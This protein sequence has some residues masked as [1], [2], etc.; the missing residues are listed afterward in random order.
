MAFKKTTAGLLL[1]AF[2]AMAGMPAAAQSTATTPTSAPASTSS[3]VQ[4]SAI[5]YANDLHLAYIRSSSSRINDD[6]KAGLTNLSAQLIERT[7]VEPHGVVG[8]NIERDDLSF[9]PFIYWPV[10]KNE[11]PLSEQAQKKVQSYINTGGVILFDVRDQT[12]KLNKSKALR[13][14][15]G[16]IDIKPLAPMGQSHTLT[17]TFYLVTGLPG[18]N[19]YGNI[20][21]ETADANSQENVSSVIIGNKNWAGAWAGRTV[22]PDTDQEEMAIRAGINI[23]MFALSGNYK[24]DQIQIPSILERL[25]K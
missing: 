2:T 21:V 3:N 6:S 18:S 1:A 5:R 12:A 22:S 15:L 24:A 11:K 10:T 19:N 13:D 16:D 25:D 9:F 8:L 14:M 7:S 23:V 20:W 4:T 17:K